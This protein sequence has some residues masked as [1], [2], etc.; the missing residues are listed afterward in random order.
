MPT[1]QFTFLNCKG[2]SIAC[3]PSKFTQVTG[4]LNSCSFSSR[5]LA[6]EMHMLPH[7][8]RPGVHLAR[9]KTIPSCKPRVTVKHPMQI[10]MLSCSILCKA[11]ELKRKINGE[12]WAGKNKTCCQLPTFPKPGANRSRMPELLHCN[13][14]VIA[15]PS[16][17]YCSHSIS[18]PQEYWIIVT[19]VQWNRLFRR[20]FILVSNFLSVA[21]FFTSLLQLLRI[22]W[23]CMFPW[24]STPPKLHYP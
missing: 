11:V 1:A 5:Q 7:C 21:L 23:R 19:S 6:K 18:P 9:E 15:S 8:F 24:W 10:V 16:Y 14:A 2:I 17:T 22:Q 20:G 4:S 12:S 3:K 13:P